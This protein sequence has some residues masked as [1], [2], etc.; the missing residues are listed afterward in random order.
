M[1]VEPE[2][3]MHNRMSGTNFTPGGGGGVADVIVKLDEESL[4]T[5]TAK[6]FQTLPHLIPSS[7]TS[8]DFT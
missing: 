6:R 4:K 2:S 8:L 3:P 1:T 5:Y 7:L